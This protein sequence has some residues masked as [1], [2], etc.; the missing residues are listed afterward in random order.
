MRFPTILGVLLIALGIIA[1]L[2]G[3][4]TYTKDKDTAELGPLDVSVEQK[5]TIP[6]PPVLGGLSLIGGVILVTV[7]S[8][9]S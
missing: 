1:F 3:G 4:I 6:L 2:W 8:K 9:R 5:E 7:G